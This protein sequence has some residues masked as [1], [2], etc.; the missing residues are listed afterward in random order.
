MTEPANQLLIVYDNYTLKQAVTP[1]WGFS[2]LITLP[3][4]QILFDTG[5]D[6]SILLQNMHELDVDL[7]KIDAVVLSHG[8]GD[9]VGGLSG[10]L[11]HK[12]DLAVYLPASFPRDF[13]EAIRQM[14]STVVE[15]RGPQM[16]YPGVYTTGELDGG[17]KEQSLVLKTDHGLVVI[18]GCAH[19]GIVKIAEHATTTFRE[20]VYLL[21]GG[22]HLMGYSSPALREIA[23]RLDAL[24]VKKIVPCH[25]SGDGAREFFKGYYKD[26][27]IPCAAGLTFALPGLKP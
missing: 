24:K 10:V 26:R 13:K 7:E 18:T 6:P 8:H 3:Q 27:Y 22:F 17:I 9:H 16:I 5:G 15:V 25:C 23:G 4:R 21:L 2:C 20:A 14:G 1:A 11:E 19:P 12:K